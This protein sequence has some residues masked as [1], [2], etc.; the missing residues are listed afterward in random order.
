MRR[1]VLESPFAGN[2]EL[3]LKYCRA[4]MRDCLMRGETPFA[5]HAL[6]TQPGV[7]DDTNPEERKLGMEAGQAWYSWAVACVVYQDLGISP[8]MKAGI[9]KASKLAMSI[10][11]RSLDAWKIDAL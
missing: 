6:H 9:E 7:L 5:S 4:A 8:G 3:N 1:V 11:Y 2:V 10:E